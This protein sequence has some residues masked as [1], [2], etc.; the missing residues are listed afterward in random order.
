MRATSAP[1]LALVPPR[2]TIR[3]THVTAGS[4]LTCSEIHDSG[5]RPL[6]LTHRRWPLP[7]HLLLNNTHTHTHIA[8]HP[9]MKIKTLFT[10]ATAAF[11]LLNAGSLSAKEFKLPNAD[12]AI[13]T[14]DIP[15][16][17]KP[18][19]IDNG[20]E[21]Q[22]EDTSFYLSIVAAG[23]GKSVDEDISATEDMIKEHKVKIDE[24]S[25]KTG[26]GKVNG[27]ETKS[28]T[29]KG[30]DEDGPCTVTILLVSIKDKVLIFTYWFTDSE[31]SKHEKEVD[32][33]QASLK[34]S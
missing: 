11:C 9:I 3:I 33:I 34:A 32:A 15:K 27:F 25:Q 29:I 6:L 28:F 1:P 10:I 4:N 8:A 21:A 30:K 13:A 2:K 16:S 31:L 22:T 18:E 23:T 24:S 17:W 20:V 19:A 7:G 14:V 5:E 12:F 26:A